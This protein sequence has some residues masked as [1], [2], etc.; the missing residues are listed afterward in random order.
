[1]PAQ[2]PTKRIASTPRKSGARP[3]VSDVK[4]EHREPNPDV[5]KTIMNVAVV[6]LALAVVVCVAMLLLR[7]TTAFQIERLEAASTEHLTS[8]DIARL[9]NVGEGTTLLNVDEAAIQE[10]LARN[11]WVAGADIERE[12]PDT[13]KIDVHERKVTMIVLMGSNGIAWYVGQGQVWIQP[14]SITAAGGRSLAEEALLTAQNQ[15]ALLVTDAP[16]TIEPESGSAV[17]DSALEAVSIYLEELPRDLASQIVSFSAA[18]E[19]ALSCI[20][21]NGVEVS[22]GS[23]TDIATKGAIVKQLLEEHPGELTY[24]NVRM[25]SNPTYRSIDSD[26]V[27]PGT[28]TSGDNEV[29][30]GIVDDSVD[31]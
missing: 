27:Q 3:L 23:A 17:S 8:D 24:I 4:T 25:P 6:V 18:S 16:S 19:D 5:L 22:L 14:A 20:L 28:G 31:E 12:F 29:A 11:P 2:H 15:G 10:G 21:S 30:D 13:L 26:S 9:A 7:A 1:M